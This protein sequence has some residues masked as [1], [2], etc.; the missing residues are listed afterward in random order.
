MMCCP[1]RIVSYVFRMS[2]PSEGPTRATRYADRLDTAAE[3]TLAAEKLLL[4]DQ[5][6]TSTHALLDE[7][8]RILDVAEAQHA[9]NERTQ[10]DVLAAFPLPAVEDPGVSAL[11]HDYGPQFRGALAEQAADA[12]AAIAAGDRTA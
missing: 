12:A 4:A 7:L 9:D 11:W 5:R 6:V 1:R 8:E 2:T 10:A 3:L